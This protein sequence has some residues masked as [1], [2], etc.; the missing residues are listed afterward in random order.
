MTLHS[1][2]PI[3]SPRRLKFANT[4]KS[5]IVRLVSAGSAALKGYAGHGRA[6][7]NKHDTAVPIS[8]NAAHEG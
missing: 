2:E 4:S 3:G 6:M 8:L 1:A 5:H 7:T